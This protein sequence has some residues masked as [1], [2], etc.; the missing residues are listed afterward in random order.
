MLK[1]SL[2]ILVLLGSMGWL[3]NPHACCPRN[4][5]Q[6]CQSAACP[7]MNSSQFCH[8]YAQTGDSEY[9][10][11]N[12][13]QSVNG[14][15]V[16]CPAENVPVSGP[17]WKIFT[18][19]CPSNKQTG[20]SV[21]DPQPKGGF[22]STDTTPAFYAFSLVFKD[23]RL[24]TLKKSDEKQKPASVFTLLPKRPPRL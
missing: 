18:S 11:S 3:L 9:I 1:S 21:N 23:Q 16:C 7:A 4:D 20:I 8:E 15:P 12:D 17:S 19:A 14:K 22:M 2:I 10:M 5:F 6:T 13:G 24:N